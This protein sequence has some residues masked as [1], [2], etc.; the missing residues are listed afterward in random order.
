[1]KLLAWNLN[2]RAARHR[3]ADWIGSAIVGHSADV[4]VLTEYIEGPDRE[5]FLS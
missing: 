5:R 4:V 2:H 1:M 3:I